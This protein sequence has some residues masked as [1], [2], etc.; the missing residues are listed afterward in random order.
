MTNGLLDAALKTE[1][2]SL[3]MAAQEQ[4]FRKNLLK[5]T[6]DKSQED[7]KCRMC[8]EADESINHLVCQCSKMTTKRI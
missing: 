4:V 6:G 1:I 2:E 8:V 3:I 7:S 5:A